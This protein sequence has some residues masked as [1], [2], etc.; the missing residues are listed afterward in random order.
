M[1][2]TTEMHQ[3]GNRL[4]PGVSLYVFFSNTYVLVSLAIFVMQSISTV[5]AMEPMLQENAVA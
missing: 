1:L 4:Q 3:Y 2:Y 5:S